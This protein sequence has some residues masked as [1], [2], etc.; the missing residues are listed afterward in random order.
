[1]NMTKIET[2]FGSPAVR[3]ISID[4]PM[5]TTFDEASKMWGADVAFGL[6]KDAAVIAVQQFIRTRL[7]YGHGESKKERMSDKQI[8][9][10]V[11]TWKPGIRVNDPVAKMNTMK[12]NMARMSDQELGAIGM[13]PAAIKTLREYVAK[14]P[15]VVAKAKKTTAPKKK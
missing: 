4:V 11:A 5:P 10:S 15:P 7:Q 8:T 14:L 1:M 3:E 6:L 2:S 9:E 13:T 12:R